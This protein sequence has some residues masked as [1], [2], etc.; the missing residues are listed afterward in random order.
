MQSKKG[1]IK[2]DMEKPSS[3]LSH[4]P[5]EYKHTIMQPV[6]SLLARY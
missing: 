6:T 4:Q 5:L 2:K 3:V 1:G